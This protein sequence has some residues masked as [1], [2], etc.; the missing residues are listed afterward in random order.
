MQ[1]GLVFF[2]MISGDIQM[3]LGYQHFFIWVLACAVPV[4]V[5]TR[6]VRIPDQ[7]GEAVQEEAA[8]IKA[9]ADCAS[10]A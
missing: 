5:M 4:L 1:L 6:F 10:Q 2:K 3:A 9:E 7:A 8:Q